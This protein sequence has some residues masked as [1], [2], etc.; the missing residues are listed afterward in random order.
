[1]A[2]LTFERLHRATE[3]DA[4]ALRALT[5]LQPAGGKGDKIFPPSYMTDGGALHK[6]AVEDRVGDDGTQTATILLDSVASQA[7][8]AEMALLEGYSRGEISFPVPYVDFTEYSDVTDYKKITVLEAPHR[9]ADAIF[10]D[11]LLDGTLFRLSEVGRAI[12]DS[13][14][15][16][17]TSMFHYSPTSLLFGLWDATGPKG[18]LGSKFQRAYVSE[19]VGFDAI[20]GKKVGS[21][22]DPLQ[23][24]KVASD[25]R[26][27]NSSDPGEVWTHTPD[28]AKKDKKGEPEYANRG[29]GKG[30]AG[31]PS[32][33]NHGNIPPVIDS[34]AGGA[35]MSRGLQT[36][37]IS[38]AAL[39]RLRFGD[40]TR[41]AETA[42]RTA[43]A[44][45]GVA[46]IAYQYEMDYDLRSRCLL[47][48][49]RPPSLELLGR[50]GSV[51]ET[52]DVS[53]D[54][55]A[56]ILA[57]AAAHAKEMG[58]GW[59]T[60]SVRL[61]PAPKLIELIRRSRKVAAVEQPA[62]K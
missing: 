52:V 54:G 25:D 29:S 33:I 31:Q 11:S 53:R 3:G 55:A 14:P 62:E 36:T 61:T 18:G 43:V 15:R 30:D 7:N 49:T 39:R 21:R 47:L 37:L 6:Y 13:T 45:L 38:L 27:F 46:A 12:T 35:T 10:R 57:S 4:V 32:K 22:I 1:M 56:K 59:E 50:D 24:E 44:A 5:E 41:E 34:Q 40:V 8:R 19:I 58:I 51:G 60:E 26:V 48:P 28:N 16:N 9:L 42:A 2:E 20:V 23:I 17:A